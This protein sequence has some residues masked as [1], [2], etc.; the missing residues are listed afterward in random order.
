MPHRRAGRKPRPKRA[1]RAPPDFPPEIWALVVAI[2]GRQST[3]RLCAVSHRF[4][5]IFTPLLYSTTTNMLLSGAQSDLLLRTLGDAHESS[6]SPNPASVV[7]TLAVPWLGRGYRR[8]EARDGLAALRNLVGVPLGGESMRGSALRALEWNVS[9]GTRQLAKLLSTPGNFPNLKEISVKCKEGAASLALFQ[10]PNLEKIGC[11]LELSPGR[12]QATQYAAW[13]LAWSALGRALKRIPSSSPLL[14][15]LNLKLEMYGGWDTN[16]S[17]DSYTGLIKTINQIRF[18]A[19]TSVELSVTAENFAARVPTADFSPFLLG[20]LALTRV[21]L[22]VDGMRIPSVAEGAD[23]PR[24]RSFTGSVP[25]CAAISVCAPE[26]EELSLVFPF[27]PQEDADDSADPGPPPP[28]G[29]SIPKFFPP[30]VSPSTKRLNLRAINK[31]N[32]PSGCDVS[33]DVLTCL[34]L[35]FPNITHLDLYL[36]AQTSP[37]RDGFSGFT[38]LERLR[39]RE[40]KDVELPYKHRRKPARVFF[41]LQKYAPQ[42][43]PALPSL[44]RLTQ[45][46]FILL[47]DRSIDEDRLGCPWCDEGWKA[48][49]VPNS[50]VEYR[51]GVDR[52]GGDAGAELVLVGQSVSEE[53]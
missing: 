32:L 50:L 8:L 40:R 10:I 53:S 33:P 30:N 15:T 13:P 11:S 28:P 22:N 2:S 14:Q 51:F 9:E 4:Y 38:A 6:L 7:Q 21:T 35:A 36:N 29:P 18:P 23:L 17:W 44:P 12:I 19:L 41:P 48:P 49:W 20:H 37:H 25:Q 5:S 42:L 45:L 34:A 26:L 52:R 43:A 27:I 31:H 24:L 39:I 47:A 16:P 3:G 46:D 1:R